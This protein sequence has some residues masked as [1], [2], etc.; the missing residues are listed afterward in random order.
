MDLESRETDQNKGAQEGLELTVWEGCGF[1]GRPVKEH[2]E[3][4][5]WTAYA[6][7]S[8][9]IGQDKKGGALI[10]REAS[11]AYSC[12]ACPAC[13]QTQRRKIALHRPLYAALSAALIILVP[14]AVN[15]GI[16]PLMQEL[17]GGSGVNA[18]IALVL[19]ILLAI[20]KVWLG[21]LM[22]A[23]GRVIGK[24]DTLLT[25]RG[26]AALQEG[27]LGFAHKQHPD[28]PLSELFVIGDGEYADL[29]RAN[30]AALQKAGIREEDLVRKPD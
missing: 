23:V 11:H 21:L 2:E 15:Y 20:A 5:R 24:T 7:R 1:C 9:K 10:Y 18:A 28:I 29:P 25:Q 3:D 17:S 6:G 12:K 27:I 19:V 26:V 30:T 4:H 13:A 16:R 8:R 14:V 22:F